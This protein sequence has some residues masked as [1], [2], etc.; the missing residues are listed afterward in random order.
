M[1]RQEVT[2]LVSAGPELA[3]NP[4]LAAIAA[5]FDEEQA[6]FPEKA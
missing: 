1:A 6:E 4:A 3:G 5:A 2:E